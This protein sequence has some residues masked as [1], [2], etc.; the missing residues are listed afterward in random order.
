ML[1]ADLLKAGLIIKA[2]G[3]K[4]VREKVEEV[5]GLISHCLASEHEEGCW[6]CSSLHVRGERRNR[7]ASSFA[8]DA[9][10]EIYEALLLGSHLRQASAKALLL[11]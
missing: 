11:L 3:V 4:D 9:F 7:D 5:A 2:C 10:C 8:P 6:V 1:G